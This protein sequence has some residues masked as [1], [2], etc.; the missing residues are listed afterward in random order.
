MND[1]Q[2]ATLTQTVSRLNTILDHL[3]DAADAHAQSCSDLVETGI[4]DYE[5]G[6][7][8]HDDLGYLE[9][10][11]SDFDVLIRTTRKIRDTFKNFQS[12]GYEAQAR[13][14]YPYGLIP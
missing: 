14:S 3:E 2:I 8:F 4:F 6:S 12:E 1:I 9:S 5:E 7:V 11:Y 10:L 13:C